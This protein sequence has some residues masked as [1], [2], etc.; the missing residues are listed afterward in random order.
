MTIAR[1]VR[2]VLL[3]LLCGLLLALVAWVGSTTHEAWGDFARFMIF[4]AVESVLFFVIG[5]A[6][7]LTPAAIT[8]TMLHPLIHLVVNPIKD[9]AL[10]T[11]AGALTLYFLD[12]SLGYSVVG[13]VVMFGCNA[14]ATL[15]GRSLPSSRGLA[16]S[17][18]LT[19]FALIALLYFRRFS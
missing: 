5:P 4:L 8:A 12:L 19:A 10:L 13:F 3:A 1:V 11:G 9:T 16:R 17:V 15:A 14:Y 18:F 2:S 6:V 7:L